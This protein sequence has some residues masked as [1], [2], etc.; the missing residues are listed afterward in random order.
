[1]ILIDH[2]DCA[3][4]ERN[5]A[6][7]EYILRNFDDEHHYL[8]IYRN[9]PCVVMGR[10]QNLIEE[11]NLKFCSENRIDIFRRISGGGTVYHDRGNINFSFITKYESAKLNNYTWF[12]QPIVKALKRMKLKAELD[13]LG[14]IYVNGYKVSGNAQF[15]SKN[16]L[17]SHGTLLYN[18]NL[19]YLRKSVQKN[20]TLNITSKA[21]KSNPAKVGNLKEMLINNI[22]ISELMDVCKHEIGVSSKKTLG[23]N[24]WDKVNL[25]ITKTYKNNQWIYGRSPKSIVSANL[26]LII[27][28]QKYAAI[29]KLKIENGRIGDAK[30]SSAG[31]FS[32]YFKIIEKRL[33]NALYSASDIRK[34]GKKINNDMKQFNV[35]L[36]IEKY[37]IG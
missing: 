7:E 5:L 13:A 17:I 25:L 4:T 29:L 27:N 19:D 6:I 32:E 3:V 18:T 15:Q 35:S 20:L 1:M 28:K 22:T 2:N 37:L 14:N 8:M 12:M 11:V 10:N 33:K 31:L 36:D 9:N 21:S 23:K 34:C 30:V 24:D 16:R 26:E